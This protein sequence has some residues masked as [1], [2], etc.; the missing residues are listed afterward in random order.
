MGRS[1]QKSRKLKRMKEEE[2]TGGWGGAE[3]GGMGST[4]CTLRAYLTSAD[5]PGSTPPFE[6]LN[7][8]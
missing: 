5:G 2:D 3:K 7:A 6:D 4:L 1:M 8:L